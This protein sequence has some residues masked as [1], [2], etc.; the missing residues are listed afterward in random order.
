MLRSAGRGVKLDEAG[1]RLSERPGRRTRRGH[2]V[3]RLSDEQLL[4]L[5]RSGDQ[6]SFNVLVDRWERPLY[7]FTYR[8][9]GQR[10]EARDVCQETFLRVYRRANRFRDG[11]RFSTWLYQI[12]LNLCRDIARRKKRWGRILGPAREWLAE[13]RP[14]DEPAD[15]SETAE[16]WAV[17][18]SER[19]LVR[20][21]LASIPSE[22]REVVVMKEFQGLKFREIAEILGCPESTVKSRMYYGLANL[23]TMI[24]DA[25]AGP[26]ERR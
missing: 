9:L 22:Q 1:V 20:Q 11:A 4:G 21:A 23:K 15:G 25:E 12:A 18:H 17:K 7:N 24:V 6:E 10:E 16:D 2:K 3:T 26:L 14:Q 8:F 19:L 5:F 13:S